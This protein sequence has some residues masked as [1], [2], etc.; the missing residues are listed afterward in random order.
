LCGVVRRTARRL[1]LVVNELTVHM[2]AVQFAWLLL[3]A[4][5]IG[6][7]AHLLDLPYAVALVLSGLLIAQ[8][9]LTAVPTIAPDIVLFAFLPPLLF[10]AAFRLDVRRLRRMAWPVLLFAVPGTIVT[11]LVVGDGLAIFVGLP[12]AVGLLFGCIVSATDPVAVVAIIKQLG[13]PER[14][15]VVPEAESLLNDGVAITLYTAVLDFTVTGQADP[16]SMGHILGLAVVGGLG[17]GA[18]LALAASRL[19]RLV[20]DPLIE[21]TLSAALAYGSFLIADAI[22]ASGA[23]ACV[24]AGLIYGAYG[25]R[26]GMSEETSRRLDDLWGFQGY[27]ANAVLFLLIGFSVDLAALW[28]NPQAVVAAIVA[29]LV[30]RIFVVDAVHL[31]TVHHG[32]LALQVEPAVRIWAGIRG[33]LT[34]VLALGLPPDTPSRGLL[35]AMTFGV[36][37]F[38]LVVQGL[39]LSPMIRMLRPVRHQ[40]VAGQPHARHHPAPSSQAPLHPAA[41]RRPR[42]AIETEGAIRPPERHAGGSAPDEGRDAGQA[43][44]RANAREARRHARAG[45]LPADKPDAPGRGSVAD[46]RP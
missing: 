5:L 22:Q 16:L 11:A 43:A 28:A 30:A 23:L 26:I 20:D 40:H 2:L 34:I 35:L 44:H 12:F 17:I 33:A 29:V 37:L 14:I 10:E 13:L 4:A 39:T 38:T 1:E 46:P 15:A 21:M 31:A 7:L 27:V 9:H 36:V 45:E 25:R 8:S 41:H 19:T 24:A 18:I 6:I 3:G 32:R 42:A